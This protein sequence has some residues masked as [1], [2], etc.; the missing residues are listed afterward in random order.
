MPG[1]AFTNC[2]EMKASNEQDESDMGVDTMPKLE[3]EYMTVLEGAEVR[4]SSRGSDNVD[5]V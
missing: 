2:A 1:M 4:T 5:I 3:P